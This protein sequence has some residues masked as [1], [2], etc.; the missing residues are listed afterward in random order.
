MTTWT[1]ATGNTTTWTKGSTVSTAM[2]GREISNLGAVMDD[3][4]YIMDD[5]VLTINDAKLQSFVAPA[6]DWTTP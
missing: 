1:P 6:T 2:Q 5:T 3:T 4:N